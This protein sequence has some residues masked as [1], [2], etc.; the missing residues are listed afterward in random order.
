MHRKKLHSKKIV[1]AVA[2]NQGIMIGK[3][4]T[5]LSELKEKF[6]EHY[7]RAQVDA[8]NVSEAFTYSVLIVNFWAQIYLT[9]SLDT[10]AVERIFFEDYFAILATLILTAI[11]F[12]LLMN[13]VIMVFGKKVKVGRNQ[14]YVYLAK[15]NAL[16]TGPL[17][18][19]IA[20]NGLFFQDSMHGCKTE[21]IRK[22][23][24][25]VLAVPALMSTFFGGTYI[26]FVESHFP[27]KS[28]L[29][30]SAKWNI[31]FINLDL[32]VSLIL[33]GLAVWILKA[34]HRTGYAILFASTRLI[35]SVVASF[36]NWEFAV[37]FKRHGHWLF[38]TVHYLKIL[39]GL[40]ELH[41]YNYH[42]GSSL[43]QF[44]LNNIILILAVLGSRA[45]INL[46]QKEEPSEYRNSNWNL[47]KVLA[48]TQL[49]REAIAAT[50]VEDRAVLTFQGIL[51]S[52]P[53]SDL[54][55]ASRMKAPYTHGQSELE[56]QGSRLILY[57][58][59]KLESHSANLDFMTGAYHLYFVN[60]LNFNMYQ[61]SYLL[62][63]LR[64]LKKD[65]YEGFINFGL[66]VLIQHKIESF[67][68]LNLH[69]EATHYSVN[70]Q[71][72][73]PTSAKIIFS[74]D[75]NKITMS[76]SPTNGLAGS[77]LGFGSSGI[78]AP[79]TRAPEAT[80][81]IYLY[82]RSIMLYEHFVKKIDS[83]LVKPIK[84]F[85]LLTLN[86]IPLKSVRELLMK[87]EAEKISTQAIFEL[88]D[89]AS[90]L[91]GS[92]NLHVLTYAFFLDQTFNDRQSSL[93]LLKA[94]KNRAL[95][96]NT[97]GQFRLNLFAGD[98]QVEPL[99][100]AVSLIID[101]DRQTFGKIKWVSRNFKDLFQLPLGLLQD[102][103][104]TNL[105]SPH[106]QAAHRFQVDQLTKYCHKDYF[107]KQRERFLRIAGLPTSYFRVITEIQISP[108]IKGG[109]QY[110]CAIHKFQLHG[111]FLVID[112]DATIIGRSESLHP[113]NGHGN[114]DMYIGR[115]I[116][117][118]SKELE[119]SFI[120]FVL[121]E[122]PKRDEVTGDTLIHKLSKKM[123]N[124]DV[125]REEWN[126]PEQDAGVDIVLRREYAV[127]GIDT[128]QNI[129]V[130]F[131]MSGMEDQ[132]GRY[133]YE[134][135]AILSFDDQKTI[136]SK[137]PSVDSDL[138]FK[139]ILDRGFKSGGSSKDTSLKIQEGIG[140]LK[141]IKEINQVNMLGQIHNLLA[142]AFIKEK[143]EH[144]S[145]GQSSLGSTFRK[146]KIKLIYGLRQRRPLKKEFALLY[147]I[148]IVFVGISIFSLFSL[149]WNFVEGFGNII[150]G[151]KG[152]KEMLA[153]DARLRA[154]GTSIILM[155]L[156]KDGN[157]I[158]Y[159]EQREYLG[160]RTNFSHSE[161]LNTDFKNLQKALNS[162]QMFL[163]AVSHETASNFTF[164]TAPFQST[165]FRSAS[166]TTMQSLPKLNLMTM[167]LFSLTF[168]ET[169]RKSVPLINF[170]NSFINE[171]IIFT[172]SVYETLLQRSAQRTIF[173]EGVQFKET[174][175]KS[176][177]IL[178]SLL[179][180]GILLSIISML[181]FLFIRYKIKFVYSG[182][183]NLLPFEVCFKKDLL[184]GLR[185][186]IAATMEQD[187][188][189]DVNSF[190]AHI[191]KYD[192]D[193][194]KKNWKPVTQRRRLHI[195][196]TEMFGLFKFIL[197]MTF[198]MLCVSVS[199][200]LELQSFSSSG[201][202]YIKA[203]NILRN[204][205]RLLVCA[206]YI[207]TNSLFFILHKR[208][209]IKGN[210]NPAAWMKVVTS[211]TSEVPVNLAL[212]RGF[213]NSRKTANADLLGFDMLLEP[214]EKY[215]DY[216][217]LGMD[218]HS[219]RNLADK[220]MELSLMEVNQWQVQ[221]YQRYSIDLQQSSSAN[222][223]SLLTDPLYFE[224]EF[225]RLNVLYPA[226]LKFQN[227]FFNS[228]DMRQSA[229]EHKV[230]QLSALYILIFLLIIALCIF[231]TLNVMRETSKAFFAFCLL[232]VECFSENA[233]MK[234]HLSQLQKL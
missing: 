69:K 77:N 29:S 84:L 75:S 24:P 86:K 101:G 125:Y 189:A 153:F 70:Q 47:K 39:Y 230:N 90:D 167:L 154:V 149:K 137:P 146:E 123:K 160:S 214:P 135:Y 81:D 109:L 178:V 218:L 60:E 232:P 8:E 9:A 104:F 179:S 183:P 201:D 50:N 44:E 20:V 124:L 78:M 215:I 168:Y 162:F 172:P 202:I 19:G 95:F 234:V 53:R 48:L 150:N 94:Y 187:N 219:F 40:Y 128:E 1:A 138:G 226:V 210:Y 173:L 229:E 223:L 118:L 64:I 190:W 27:T 23:I 127:L 145:V 199:Q 82:I 126:E 112:N 195:S 224:L 102:T 157:L 188:S 52:L 67:Y 140:L 181:I 233:R 225:I 57:L 76:T 136:V 42:K 206:Y 54:E 111:D 89:S 16:L 203:M 171:Y 32:S 88:L 22:V 131:K 180:V 193:N 68:H 158:K 169:W 152:I 208:G 7:F 134:T 73:N 87:I 36:F 222:A 59:E 12:Y 31:I 120:Q 142:H 79:T 11:P 115:K 121:K 166:T 72:T 132:S 204:Q 83:V 159:H 176:T 106:L 170:D 25:W 97:Q 26:T 85:D 55:L 198:L 38:S 66:N 65:L 161:T 197:A 30:C 14:L 177:Y 2:E 164:A 220:Q 107:S 114:F 5:W 175:G 41:A 122:V 133:V 93:K 99:D 217:S 200:L 45:L 147:A 113:R 100:E 231:A 151:R 105:L 116:S 46:A 4:E 13:K 163:G 56:F 18:L 28:I 139:P 43:L 186:L 103:D 37:F 110:L 221:T 15:I 51:K 108:E 129:N 34:D 96:G 182:L 71:T 191:R 227:N 148:Q 3:K 212:I 63:R 130:K 194:Y 207:Q 185:Q 184:E 17:T 174:K 92:Q 117:T 61:L 119:L 165:I 141:N 91:K 21:I 228:M 213:I 58:F 62:A 35:L 144:E 216:N 155:H 33:N 205:H 80:F 49:F 6:Y 143:D 74:N 98:G 156:A 209:L 10:Y 211:S 196:L 192:Y